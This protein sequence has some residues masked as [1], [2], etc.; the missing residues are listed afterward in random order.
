MYQQAISNRTPFHLLGAL[1]TAAGMR[2]YL[3]FEPWKNTRLF[4]SCRDM[5]TLIAPENNSKRLQRRRC[6][7]RTRWPELIEGDQVERT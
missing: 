6:T 7:W 4:V 2:K 3:T 1:A 5:P